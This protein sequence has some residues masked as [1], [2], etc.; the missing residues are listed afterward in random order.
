MLD[1]IGPS[2]SFSF[3]VTQ[4]RR[5][6]ANAERGGSLQGQTHGHKAFLMQ[7]ND[8]K[9]LIAKQAKYA[10]MCFFRSNRR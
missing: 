9:L 5:I 6:E 7:P 1:T 3:D 10:P 2:L 4:A 8:A